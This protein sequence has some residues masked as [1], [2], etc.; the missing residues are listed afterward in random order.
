MKLV[1]NSGR[2]G[3]RVVPA[4]VLWSDPAWDLALLQAEG[5]AGLPSV[6][7]ATA[8]DL[9][10]LREVV[11]LGFPLGSA[12]AAKGEDYPTVNVNKGK[13]RA[14]KGADGQPSEIEAD[15]SI[16]SGNRAARSSTARGAWRAS[17]SPATRTGSTIPAIAFAA[18]A[19]RLESFLSRPA[20]TFEPLTVTRAGAGTNRSSSRPSS[21]PS[22]RLGTR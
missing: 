22:S 16:N 8:A 14:V 15:V 12:L 19:N 5:V 10:G 3:Q 18:P 7:I 13:V 4:K 20:I 1:L 6:Q 9:A 2:E 11:A 17:S 21:V